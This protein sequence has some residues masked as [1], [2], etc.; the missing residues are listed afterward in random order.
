MCSDRSLKE[1]TLIATMDGKR[2]HCSQPLLFTLLLR[3]CVVLVG[4]PFQYTLS[5]VLKERLSFMST[6]YHVRDQD[7]LTFD[8]LRQ[9]CTFVSEPCIHMRVRLFYRNNCTATFSNRTTF[10]GCAM[11]RPRD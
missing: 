3:S 8:A 7:F 2:F 1:S 10:T 6:N 9:V 5:Y 4:V 11:H